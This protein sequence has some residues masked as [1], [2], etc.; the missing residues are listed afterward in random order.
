[1]TTRSG[2]WWESSNTH[3][4]MHGLNEKLAA[5]RDCKNR[6]INVVILGAYMQGR[7]EV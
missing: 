3:G 2:P 4:S 6:G 1:M 7:W 5:R